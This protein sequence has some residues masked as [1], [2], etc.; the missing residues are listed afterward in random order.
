MYPAAIEC[1]KGQLSTQSGRS[2]SPKALGA[3]APEPTLAV[4]GINRRVGW[5]ADIRTEFL[6][7]LWGL[8]TRRAQQLTD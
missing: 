4:A 7:E 3:V 2:C 8:T 1:A 6:R 5:R